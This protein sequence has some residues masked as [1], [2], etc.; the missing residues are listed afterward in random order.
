MRG[1]SPGFLATVARVAALLAASLLA[2]AAIARELPPPG[3]MERCLDLIRQE[4]F[5]EARATLAPIVAEH[6]RWQRAALLLGLAYFE[7]FRHG[8]ARPLLERAI[9]L[10]PA[11]PDALAARLHL[12]WSLYYLGEPEAARARFEEVLRARPQEADAHFGLGLIAFDADDVEAAAGRLGTAIDLARRAGDAAVEGK[13]RARLAD[14]H[15]RKGNLDEARSELETAV[16]LRPDAYEAWYKLSR[17]LQRLGD[18][19]GAARALATHREIRERVRP[20][21]RPRESPM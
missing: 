3:T 15:V 17:V 8:E 19:E 14:V 21:N 12:G 5:D 1:S 4:R 6:P 2:S 18:A 10:D 13:A 16:R 20:R 9:E 11:T 7:E